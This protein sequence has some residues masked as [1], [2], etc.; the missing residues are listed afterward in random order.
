MHD[1]VGLLNLLGQHIGLFSDKVEV[2]AD[3][4]LLEVLRD[5][6]HRAL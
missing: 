1:K 5:S 3:D 4:A 6:R 2:T